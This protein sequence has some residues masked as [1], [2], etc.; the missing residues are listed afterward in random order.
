MIIF[1]DFRFEA[2]HYL[3][4]VPESHKCRRLH[5]HSYKVRV[6][7]KGVPGSNSGWLMDF[8]DLKATI[9]SVI[10]P[11]DHQCL[12]EIAGLENPTAENLAIWI[13]NKVKNQVPG[14]YEVHVNESDTSGC[15]YDGN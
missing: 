1:K 3:P 6:Y 14:L 5:G 11:L 9:G 15:I 12:N 7:V 8:A 10:T 4:N 2:A 13:W